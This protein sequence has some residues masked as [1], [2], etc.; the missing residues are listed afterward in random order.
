MANFIVSG[1]SNYVKTNEDVLIKSVVLG[2]V[3]GD[4]IANLAKQT[5]IKN[6][7]RLSYLNVDPTFQDGAN[8]GFSAVG[9]TEFTERDL[10]TAQYKVQD[11]YCDRLLLGKFGEWKVKINSQKDASDLPFEAELMDEIIG[12]I[13]AGMEKEVWLGTATGTSLIKGF[14]TLAAGDDSASTVSVEIAPGTSVYDAIKAVIM[15]IPERIIDDATVFVSPAIYRSFVMSMVEKG[16]YHY[17][18]DGNVE[19]KDITFP[20]TDIK[21]HKTIGLTGDKR[22]IYASSYKNMVYG[23]DLMGDEEKVKLFYDEADELTKVNIRW[24]AGVMTYFPDM[25]VLGTA[26]ADLV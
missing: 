22:H 5:G 16:Y 9:S 13:N 20:G 17:P 7:E 24:N 11:Q 18:A 23:C 2:E 3:K 14:V 12:G 6:K 25:V 8:C 26:A 1:L 21:V 19:D 4:T 15:Q 10:T